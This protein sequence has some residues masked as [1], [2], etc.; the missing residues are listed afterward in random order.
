MINSAG[1]VA[2]RWTLAHS[3]DAVQRRL[4]RLA[5]HGS[6]ADGPVIIEPTREL[7]DDRLL[8]AGH[9]LVPVHPTASWAARPRSGP[10]LSGPSKTPT[11]MDDP[12]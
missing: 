6:P 4:E 1:R 9:L 7:V 12:L 11:A 3:E 5:Q 10:Y 2:E 8:T